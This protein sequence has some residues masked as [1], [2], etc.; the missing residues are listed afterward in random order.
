MLDDDT[1]FMN[2]FQGK[3]VKL[4]LKT[5]SYLGVLH[6]INSNK[7]LILTNVKSGC[8]GCELTGSRLFFGHEILNVEFSNEADVE[9]G[10]VTK[11]LEDQLKVENFQPYRKTVY[12]IDDEGEEY[13]HFEVIDGFLE[14]FGRAVMTIKKQ[15]V[16]GVG[17]DGVEMYK[18]GRLCWLQI[19]T[20]NKVYLFDILSLGSRAFKNGLTMILENKRI[21]KVIHDCRAI[22]RCLLAQFGVKLTNVF[23]TQ[24]AD[25]LC[26]R[27][28]TGG[29]LP[30]RVSTLQEVEETEMWYKRPCPLPLLK[31][32]ALSV[33]HLQPLR[34]ILLDSLLT[35]Y[36]GLVDAYLSNSQY[37]LDN[38]ESI[39]LESVFELPSEFQLLEQMYR[40]RRE[41]AT[42]QYPVTEK[43]LLA[44]AIP[45]LPSPPLTSSVAKE[46]ECAPRVKEPSPPVPMEAD[47]NQLPLTVNV[48]TPVSVPNTLNEM[49]LNGLGRGCAALMMQVIGRGRLFQQR[50]LDSVTTSKD[51]KREKWAPGSL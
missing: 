45:R 28:E 40:E 5:S 10:T 9:D 30:D 3:R 36:V 2:L 11:G 44:R 15:H 33:I 43:G 4:T 7:T 25:V 16:V 38:L 47:Q 51:H 18:D 50:P 17:A 35:D 42:K 21:L 32:M 41:H 19:A 26:F 6:R 27:S 13:I 39:N 12:N 22:A 8:N 24:V 14:K 31:V 20:K 34:M 46:H 37:P 49:P 1:L 29:F 23:D 48:A